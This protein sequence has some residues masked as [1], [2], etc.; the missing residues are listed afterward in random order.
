MPSKSRNRFSPTKI[1]REIGPVPRVSKHS[2]SDLSLS[3]SPSLS[4]IHSLT[5]SLSI[6]G[7]NLYQTLDSSFLSFFFSH[8]EIPI[9]STTDRM[10]DRA[11]T[12]YEFSQ[13]IT[14]GR[15]VTFSQIRSLS[16][17]DLIIPLDFPFLSLSFSFLSFSFF[18]CLF[19]FS[20]VSYRYS[21]FTPR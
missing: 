17:S 2:S 14:R 16:D 4:L 19:L 21:R 11:I 8:P 7:S 5:L 9:G 1:R 18:F 13:S 12:N 10:G 3:L 15:K 6:G 20:S